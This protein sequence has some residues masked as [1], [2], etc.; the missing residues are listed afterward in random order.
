MITSPFREKSN[1]YSNDYYSNLLPNTVYIDIIW[2]IIDLT[3]YSM[4]LSDNY[5]INLLYL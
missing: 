5:S 3:R 1:D 4:P 2:I